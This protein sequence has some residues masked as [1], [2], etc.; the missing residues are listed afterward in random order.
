M[1]HGT[2]ADSRSMVNLRLWDGAAALGLGRS[3]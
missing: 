3:S 2:R 1:D